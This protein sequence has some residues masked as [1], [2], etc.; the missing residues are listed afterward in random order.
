[1]PPPPPGNAPTTTTTTTTCDGG[2]II[3]LGGDGNI[4]LVDDGGN[5]ILG[6]DGNIIFGGDG[7]NIITLGIITRHLPA[8]DIPKVVALLHRIC[9]NYNRNIIN[10]AA[11]ISSR[12]S[13]HL[14]QCQPRS[15]TLRR[16]PQA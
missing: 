2:N 9:C 4:I 12:T 15:Q 6:G 14:S 7:G 13:Q 1:M 11:A 10:A 5:I 8:I 3:N 16:P